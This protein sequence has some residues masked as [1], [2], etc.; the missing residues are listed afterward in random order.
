MNNVSKDFKNVVASFKYGESEGM[1]RGR[2]VHDLTEDKAE[3]LFTNT[4][5]NVEKMWMNV[6]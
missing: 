5:L 3:K 6:G 1:R 4:E 2:Y